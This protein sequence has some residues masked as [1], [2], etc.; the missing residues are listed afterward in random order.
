MIPKLPKEFLWTDLDTMDEFF[1]LDPVNEDFY[2][3]FMIMRE[4]PFDVK[5]DAVKVFNE[6]YYH[7]TIF[8][9]LRPNRFKMSNYIHDIKANLGWNYSAKLVLSMIYWL[10]EASPQSYDTF[11]TYIFKE[12]S[13]C[14]YWRPFN[15]CYDHLCYLNK[16]MKYDFKPRPVSLRSLRKKYINWPEITNYYEL[17]STKATINVWKTSNDKKKVAAMIR[18]SLIEKKPSVQTE[19]YCAKMIDFLNSYIGNGIPKEPMVKSPREETLQI[20]ISELEA[21]VERLNMLM[22][23]KNQSGED[24]MFTLVQMVDYCKGCVEW[25]DVKSIVA[26]LN[27][28]LRRVGTDKD[29]DLVDSIEAEFINRKYGDTVMGDKNEFNDNSGMNRITLPKGISASEALRLLQNKKKKEDG[30]EG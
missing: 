19:F 17:A 14:I 10:I 9:Y 29:S 12:L 25:S 3:T 7:A 30:E 13:E 22:K 5:L 11:K 8:T 21:E 1:K 4:E 24:R 26:M 20:R 2:E 15:Q 23:K 28:L 16:R 27:K 6:V 18:D